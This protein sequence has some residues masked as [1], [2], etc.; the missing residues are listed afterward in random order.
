MRALIDADILRYEIGFAAETGWQGDQTPPFDYVAH[1]LDLRIANIMEETKSDSYCLFLSK[2]KSFRNDVAQT[3][4][5]K[6]TRKEHKPYHFK[7]LTAYIKGLKTNMVASNIEADDLMCI[8]QTQEMKQNKDATIICSRDKD[9]RQMNGWVYSW[10]LGRQPGFGPYFVHPPG[11]L[12]LDRSGKVAKLVGVGDMFFWA[13]ML[14][15]DTVDNIGAVKGVGPVG[16]YEL[17]CTAK[18][19]EDAKM[20]V[21]D[22]YMRRHGDNWVQAIEEMGQLLWMVRELNEDGSP[23]LWRV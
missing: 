3:K 14:M 19:I 20:I 4:V 7:N 6:G 18:T 9:L 13:Q 11:W 22:Q 17:L 2:G 12:K 8:I 21:V 16:A 5:Y 15:G 10:E 23:K 1:L